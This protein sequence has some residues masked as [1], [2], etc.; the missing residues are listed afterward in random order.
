LKSKYPVI[1][2]IEQRLCCKDLC[3]HSE[4]EHY[5]HLHSF[6]RSTMSGLMKALTYGLHHGCR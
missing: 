4:H 6:T 2:E 5:P 3:E 1:S